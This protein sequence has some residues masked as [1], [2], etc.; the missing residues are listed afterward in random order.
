MAT[1]SM[2]VEGR[3]KKQ[4]KLAFKNQAARV[5]IITDKAHKDPISERAA[6][7]RAW[8]KDKSLT[9]QSAL[10]VG[11]LKTYAGGP[12]RRAG[13][14]S[15]GETLASV[16][17]DLRQKTGINF[18]TKPWRSRK[19][20]EIVR[21]TKQWLK[22]MLRPEEISSKRVEN[23][24]QAIVRN[25]IIRGDYGRNSQATAKAKGFNRFMIDTA[26]LVKGIKGKLVGRVQ[27]PT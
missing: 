20:Q 23:L 22:R 4:L 14:R 6:R 18:Y 3:F 17:E 1:I 25:P 9:V 19:N 24:L 2:R 27:K 12:A 5:G 11:T 21:F 16:S 15:S 13:S 26:Q 8:R 7:K 10:S